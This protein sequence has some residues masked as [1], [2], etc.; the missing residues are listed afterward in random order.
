ME[1]N[2]RGKKIDKKFLLEKVET[3][4]VKSLENFINQPIKF[5]SSME[6]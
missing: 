1:R 2:R 6:K 5:L 4:E 3:S